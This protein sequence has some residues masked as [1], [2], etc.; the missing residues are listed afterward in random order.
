MV[1]KKSATFR[2]APF[3]ELLRRVREPR[4]F[5]QVVAGPRQVGKTTMTRQVV[6][7]AGIPHVWASADEPALRE[8][9]WLSAR[10]QEARF[11]SRGKRGSLLVLDEIQKLP[12][13]SESVKRLWD[14]DSANGVNVKAV[15]LG[16]SPLLM[17][18]GL[19]ES[20]AGRFEMLRLG[21][22][23]FPE[24][25]EAFGWGL[26][27]YC[28]Y[29]G[30]PGAAPLVRDRERWAAYVGESL[31]ETSVSRDVLLL[32]R[33]D[34]PALLR[35]LFS[36]AASYS[37]EILSFNKMLGQLQDAGNTVTLA[38]Y[39]ELL[40]GAGLVTGLQKFSGSDVRR[41]GSSPKLLV[42]NTALMTSRWGVDMKQARANPARW[43]RLVE[44]VVGA[45]LIAAGFEVTYWRHRGA[46]VD[47]VIRRRDSILGVEVTSGRRKDARP[48][49]QPFLDRFEDARAL[50]VGADGIPLEDF[51]TTD[52]RDLFAM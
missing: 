34:K 42:M 19:T 43:G 16:S 50:I 21:H 30:Y 38:H 2:R 48:G 17:Q 39:L 24:M 4:R 47:F 9:G 44:T 6:E 12:D 49:I 3:H 33:I 25:R 27:R 35:Q 28:F 23:T 52:A 36:L 20:L 31:V 46:E 11:R 7:Q 26:D 18:A 32:T 14:E 10:W 51:L 5:I 37:G 45:H 8:R 15:I 41:K 22:W 40:A 1:S 29:G 13:W